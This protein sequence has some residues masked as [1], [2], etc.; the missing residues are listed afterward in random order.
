MSQGI[1]KAT[2]SLAARGIRLV[3]AAASACGA[4]QK[5]EV[6]QGVAVA[7]ASAS[8]Y[9]AALGA[10]CANLPAEVVTSCK[11]LSAQAGDEACGEE[12]ASLGARCAPAMLLPD[13]GSTP[14]AAA[15]VDASLPRDAAD[16]GRGAV[17]CTLLTAC[18]TSPALPK[19][20]LATC[21]SVQGAGAEAECASLLADLTSASSCTGVGIGLAGACPELQACCASSSFPGQF[22]TQ[23]QG[24]VMAGEAASCA[25]DLAT[26]VPAG[27]CGGVVPDSDGGHL[28]D[29]DCAMLSMC[30][31]EI[32]FPASS[33]ST[34]ESV[35]AANVGDRCLSA[36]D[37]YVALQYCE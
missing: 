14:D 26:F 37:S 22:L 31:G 12:L 7:D 27:Y 6:V 18:C 35:A 24:T 15:I 4:S 32:T 28:P 23:C 11:Q 8:A 13:A 9:C 3:L 33:V 16:A 1:P 21:Q 20:E 5:S 17:A 2:M 30:C 36:Y 10:C 34:C 19:G 25:S 29:P